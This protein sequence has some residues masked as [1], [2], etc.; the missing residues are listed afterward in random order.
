[1]AQNSKI[2]PNCRKK[3]KQQFVGVQHCTCGITW[4]KDVGFLERTSD[5]IFALERRT[6]G[7]KVK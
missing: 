6:I 4:K 5:M 7:K 2:C 1:M 3:M